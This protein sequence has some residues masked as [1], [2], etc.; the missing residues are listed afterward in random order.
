MDEIYLTEPDLSYADDIWAFRQEVL[1]ID[2]D[3]E[4]RFA[5]CMSLDTSSSAG[6]WIDICKLRKNSDTCVSTGAAVPSTMYLAVRKSDNRI[7]GITDLR[8]HIDHPIL[9]TWLVTC[10][11]DN[12]ASEKTIISNGGVFEKTIEVDG[13]LLKRFWIDIS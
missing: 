3:S 6:E 5:G 11:A 1:E 12:K 10:N 2:A 7:V 8:H 4:D 13:S 9:G